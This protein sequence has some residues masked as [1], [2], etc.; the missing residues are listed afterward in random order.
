MA[1]AKTTITFA[2]FAVRYQVSVTRDRL[3][4]PEPT[5][6][7]REDW[8]RAARCLFRIA[9]VVAAV[10]VSLVLKDWGTPETF[11]IVAEKV[12]DLAKEVVEYAKKL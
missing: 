8:D 9:I 2:A 11:A 10:T 3:R 5:D 4:R 1:T 6:Q 12:P 7:R